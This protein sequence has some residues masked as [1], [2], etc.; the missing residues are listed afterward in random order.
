LISDFMGEVRHK[1]D[2]TIIL[3]YMVGTPIWILLFT[4][5]ENLGRSEEKICQ[6]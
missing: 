3:R 5:I 2:S 6:V 4:E 1:A